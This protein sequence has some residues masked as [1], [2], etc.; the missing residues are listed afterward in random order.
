MLIATCSLLSC[1]KESTETKT[2]ESKPVQTSNT[3]DARISGKITNPERNY[4]V[5]RNRSNMNARK[6]SAVLNSDGK[7]EFT[8]K[9]D[10]L[11]G[12]SLMFSDPKAPVP[13]S[14]GD[15][16]PELR[17]SELS[18][19]LDKGFDIRVTF[20]AK[21]PAGSLS[22]TGNGAKLSEYAAQKAF[23]GTSMNKQ[24]S[25]KMRSSPEEYLDFIDA[26]YSDM[27]KLISQIPDG[28]SDFPSGFK[29]KERT[30]L[31]YFYYRFKMNLA[32]EDLKKGPQGTYSNDEKFISFMKEVPFN[33]P[34]EISNS[35]YVNLVSSYADFLMRKNNPGK[36]FTID[37][38][39]AMKYQTYKELFT[40]PVT[41]DKMLYDYLVRYVSMSKQPWHIEAVED[42][43]RS[44]S[45][46]SLKK[47]I[48]NIKSGAAGKNEPEE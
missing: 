45:S 11:T 27:E 21:D 9:T 48:R 18:V 1:G 28:S 42:F 16:Q 46:D 38:R 44:A 40:D 32:F 41:R 34:E 3:R 25:L 33:N 4:V 5:L 29:E 15:Q 10:T 2:P 8:V 36:V 22:I 31:K 17:H 47:E 30:N 26:F 6:D 19:V 24:A 12:F 43:A 13:G 23:K 7:F 37:E 35:N 14:A 39:M 20:D